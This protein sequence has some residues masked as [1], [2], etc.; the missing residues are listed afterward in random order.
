MNQGKIKILFVCMGNICRSPSAEGAFKHHV[1]MQ[2]KEHLFEIDSAGTQAYHIGEQPDTRAQI[3][4]KARDIDLSKQRARQVHESDFYYYDY[5][6]AMDESNLA[7][8]KNDCSEKYQ[9][10][11]S[12]MLDNCPNSML[13]NVPD[14][15]YDGG[16]DNVF[17]MIDKCS[18]FILQNI[19]KKQ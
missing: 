3:A 6:F 9:H 17:A 8:L 15:Y 14:P 19:L 13:K 18:A 16:F 4:A 11:L 5:L 1:S 2:N 12:L 7:H 10:K